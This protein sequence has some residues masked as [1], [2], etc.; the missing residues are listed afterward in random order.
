[1]TRSKGMVL[2]PGA[3]VGLM[4]TDEAIG[5]GATR[6]LDVHNPGAPASRRTHG[7]RPP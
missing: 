3:A 7:R 4:E 1:M 5:A 2:E 6:K